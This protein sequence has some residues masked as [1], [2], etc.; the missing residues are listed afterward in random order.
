MK[1]TQTVQVIIDLP[2]PNSWVIN[3]ALNV[4]PSVCPKNKNITKQNKNA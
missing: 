4:R 3:F 2:R 1:C